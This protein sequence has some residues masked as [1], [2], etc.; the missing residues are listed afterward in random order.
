MAIGA[1]VKVA[2][3]HVSSALPQV[4]TR[5]LRKNILI[6]LTSIDMCLFTICLGY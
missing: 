6:K 5:L 1:M 4:C 2:P 3:G